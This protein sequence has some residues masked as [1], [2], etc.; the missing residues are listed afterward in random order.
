MLDLKCLGQKEKRRIGPAW[1]ELT[2]D[3]SK[4]PRG[5]FDWAI[6]VFLSVSA[7]A[8]RNAQSDCRSPSTI[9][10]HPIHPVKY[11]PL[12]VSPW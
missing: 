12:I 8:Q 1:P 5:L 9:H 7:H 3:A 10:S 11:K 6:W 4:S 2:N